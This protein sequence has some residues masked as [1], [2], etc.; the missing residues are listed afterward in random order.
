[1]SSITKLFSLIIFVKHNEIIFYLRPTQMVIRKTLHFSKIFLVRG[2][3]EVNT[4]PHHSGKRRF[5]HYRYTRWCSE[6]PGFEGPVFDSRAL[7]W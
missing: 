2:G 7:R 5:R 6:A 4:W 3:F 1:L